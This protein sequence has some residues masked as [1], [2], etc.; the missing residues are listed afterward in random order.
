VHQK[1]EKLKV[2]EDKFK[3]VKIVLK[4]QIYMHVSSA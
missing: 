2:T 1:P 4:G 3:D